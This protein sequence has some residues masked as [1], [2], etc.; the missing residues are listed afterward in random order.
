MVQM[1]RSVT[2]EDEKVRQGYA[3]SYEVYHLC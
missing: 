3:W 2:L 1:K